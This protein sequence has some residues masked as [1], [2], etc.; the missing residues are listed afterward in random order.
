MSRSAVFV[1]GMMLI[2]G[3]ATITSRQGAEH[4]DKGIGYYLPRQNLK[5]TMTV[6]D[7]GARTIAVTPGPMLPDLRN[8]FFARINASLN[9]TNNVKIGVTPTGL[10]DADQTGTFTPATTSLLEAIATSAGAVR[11]FQAQ[12]PANACLYPGSYEAMLLIGDDGTGSV[13]LCGLTIKA[14]KDPNL[15]NANTNVDGVGKESVCPNKGGA[16]FFYRQAIPYSVE[17]TSS[18]AATP[19]FTAT[20]AL[21]TTVSPCR[22]LPT[23]RSFF[24]KAVWTTTFENGVPKSYDN[25]V[26]SEAVALAS[27]PAEVISAYSRA[28]TAGFTREKDES[29]K[30]KDELNM[31]RQRIEAE[32]KLL[33]CQ[34]AVK[35]AVT[36]E[37]LAKAQEAC[38]E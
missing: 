3:C 23:P 19:E 9:G 38:N 28:I 14:I 11:A 15:A 8:P 20:V 16:G 26:E 36:P 5:V 32:L 35:A 25:E 6:A 7:T 4:A 29:E 21:V 24:A 33:R 13:N 30:R 1:A 27:V 31:E 17:A 22:F 18:A 12:P 37:D 2:S 34:A 10:L